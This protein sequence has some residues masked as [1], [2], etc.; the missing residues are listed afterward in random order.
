MDTNAYRIDPLVA[1]EGHT[2]W[3]STDAYGPYAA[4]SCGWESFP[5]RTKD[6]V[7]MQANAHVKAA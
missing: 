7:A 2:V 5:V 6:E 1:V 4:C 3:A